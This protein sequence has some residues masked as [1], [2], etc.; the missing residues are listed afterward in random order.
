MNDLAATA[1]LWEAA[2]E[3]FA[4]VGVSESAK[5]LTS[6]VN[7]LPK[8]MRPG[9][10]SREVQARARCRGHPRLPPGCPPSSGPPQFLLLAVAAGLLGDH[11]G[12]DR[13]R[14][15]AAWSPA[16]WTR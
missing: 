5:L 15:N 13:R 12:R 6:A 11:A 16:W 2:K 4:E 9:C 8:Y 3:R 14:D 10:S 1:R 7:L